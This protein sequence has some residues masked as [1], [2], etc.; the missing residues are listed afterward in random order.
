M[1][2]SNSNTLQLFNY[3]EAVV[4]TAVIDGEP[5]F[6]AKDVA[7]LL[8][9]VDANGAIT[10]HC[11][12]ALKRLPLSTPGGMQQVTII[13]EPNLYRLI[14]HSKLPGAVQFERWVYEE[15]LPTIRKT[16]GAYLTTAKAEE[17]LADPK[18]IMGL[19]QQVIDLKAE[20]DE[21]IRTKAC[22]SDSK[23]A[24]AMQKASVLSRRVNKLEKQLGIAK[25]YMQASAIPYIKDFFGRNPSIGLWVVI[26]QQ[27]KRIAVEM[28]EQVI[29]VSSEKF[30]EVNTYSIAVVER[31]KQLLMNDDTYLSNWRE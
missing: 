20:R 8:G 24:R 26:G 13:D 11:K 9:Y 6:V 28:Q 10:R 30:G 14:A 22:I 4:R 23:T 27:M 7:E 17:L 3:K 19:A 21:A 18:L 25:N 29:K 2:P 5:W 16:G 15:V 31:F 12:G 1:K